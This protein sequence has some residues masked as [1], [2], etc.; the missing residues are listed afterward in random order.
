MMIHVICLKWGDKYGP[1]YVNRLYASIKRNTTKPF[2][3]WCFTENNK[4]IHP[5]VL[6]VPLKYADRLDS[7]WNKIMLFSNELPDAIATGDLI[8]YVDLDTVITGNIDELITEQIPEIILLRDFYHGIAKTA[9]HVGSG[10]MMWKHGDYDFIWDRF[11]K[12]PEE[13]IAAA[14]PHGDQWWVEHCLESWYCWQDIFP[15]RVVSFKLH[16]H[17]GLP[18]KAKIICYHGKPSI[19]ESVTMTTHQATAGKRWTTQPA[20]WILDHWRDQ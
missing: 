13:A 11:I 15:G 2:K 3:F 17:E 9:G 19:P 5:D 1:E 6:T 10:L 7:W 4:S 16:C 20:P 14:H 8:F 18:Q 12:N